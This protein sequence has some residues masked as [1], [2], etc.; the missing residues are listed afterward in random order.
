MCVKVSVNGRH[1]HLLHVDHSGGAHDISYDAWNYLK[2][3]KSARDELTMG[4][5]IGAT[6]KHVPMH[7]CSHLIKTHGGHSK[8]VSLPFSAATGVDFVTSCPAGSWVK[9]NHKF[10]NIYDTQCQYGVDKVCHLH[11]DVSNQQH[12]KGSV[13]GIQTPLHSNPVYNIQYGTG[14]KVLAT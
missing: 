12:C 7:E 13:L 4:G 2:V 3:G 10:I 8:G 1:V 9:K 14:K 11:M 6:Y 5:G